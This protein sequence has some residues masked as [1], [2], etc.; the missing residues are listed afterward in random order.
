ML[1]RIVACS[2]AQSGV[3]RVMASDSDASYLVQKIEGTAASAEPY[4]GSP[5]GSRA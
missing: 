4:L 5:W 1:T 3:A 2:S